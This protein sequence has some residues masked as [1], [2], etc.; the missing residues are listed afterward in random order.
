M[1]VR[2]IWYIS[3]SRQHSK[4]TNEHITMSLSAVH[5]LLRSHISTR[6]HPVFYLRVLPRRAISKAVCFPM[7]VLAPVIRTVFPSSLAL[8]L[9]TPP[10]IHLRKASRPAPG[11]HASRPDVHHASIDL[12]P[13]WC[14]M[15]SLLSNI[16]CNANTPLLKY[17]LFKFIVD[18]NL[19]NSISVCPHTD[20]SRTRMNISVLMEINDLT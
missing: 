5:V 20:D 9:H 14:K 6:N 3:M 7:P 17:I 1:R 16:W 2:A 15:S 18:I 8:L 13:E 12:R 11:T 4:E 19:S 10:A